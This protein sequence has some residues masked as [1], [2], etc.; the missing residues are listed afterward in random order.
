MTLFPFHVLFLVFIIV[1]GMLSHMSF[2]RLDSVLFDCHSLRY[3]F[4][5]SVLLVGINSSIIGYC[6]VALFFTSLVVTSLP[7]AG[8]ASLF[9]LCSYLAFQIYV[10]DFCLCLVEKLF[11][12]PIELSTQLILSINM[13][14][15]YV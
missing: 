7:S 13:L 4:H 6:I 1:I 9:V 10:F 3:F 2:S 5:L 11:A 15:L 8:S 14:N 12:R